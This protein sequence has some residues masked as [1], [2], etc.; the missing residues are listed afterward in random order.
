MTGKRG[1]VNKQTNEIMDK[2]KK[3]VVDGWWVDTAQEGGR[4]ADKEPGF[5]Q[6][7]YL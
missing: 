4:W 5:R 6:C 7:S 2:Q 1:S 3:L